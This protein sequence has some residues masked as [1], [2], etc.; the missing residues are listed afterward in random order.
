METKGIMNQID[1]NFFSCPH[2]LL[3]S[4]WTVVVGMVTTHFLKS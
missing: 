1:I 4:A 2:L 3:I